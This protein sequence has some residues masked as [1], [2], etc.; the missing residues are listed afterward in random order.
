M[1]LGIG[2]H[3]TGAVVV[4]GT[5]VPDLMPASG[6]GGGRAPSLAPWHLRLDPTAPRLFRKTGGAGVAVSTVR[7]CYK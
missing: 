7:V 3:G 5:E 6:K 4:A 2:G 1:S